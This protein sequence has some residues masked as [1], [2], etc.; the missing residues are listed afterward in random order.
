LDGNQ[1][2]KNEYD[3]SI[4]GVITDNAAAEIKD[5]ELKNSRLLV[6][7]GV[8][9]VRVSSQN[10][11]IKEGDYI[12]ASSKE[13]VGMKATK[14]G[15]VLGS[16]MEGYSNQDV[17]SIGIIQVILNIHPES[18]LTGSTGNLLQFIRQGISVPIFSPVESLRY[19]LAIAMVLISFTL[20]MVYFGRAS[21]AGIE[22]IGRN[23][24][25]K[26]V[27]QFTVVMNIILTIVIVIVG[28]GIA[29]LILVL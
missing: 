23:P 4:F 6:M 26:K 19:L 15:F 21:R 22:A 25:A 12:T 27:I 14:N 11:D 29:Y 10:G 13:G 8:A 7:D 3:T 2:C 17:N 1:R 5:T 16:A 28:L 20:G 24:L 18:S 9:K